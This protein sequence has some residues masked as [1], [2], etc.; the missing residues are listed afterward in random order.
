MAPQVQDLIAL[1]RRLAFLP[2]RR[3][4]DRLDLHQSKQQQLYTYIYIYIYWGVG[5]QVVRIPGPV[6]NGRGFLVFD[7]SLR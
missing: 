7:D 6:L 4:P 2:L 3:V 1:A 5:F